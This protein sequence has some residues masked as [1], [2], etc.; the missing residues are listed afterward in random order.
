[1]ASS[2]SPVSRVLSPIAGASALVAL[3]AAIAFT[4]PALAQTV[5]IP[6]MV[7][8]DR[9]VP[10]TAVAV[11]YGHQFK[12]DVEDPGTEMARHNALF[13][14]SHRFDLGEKT[15]LTAMG[16]YTLHGYDFSGNGGA[17]PN[18]TNFYQWDDVHR[19]VLAGVVGHQVGDR[20]RVL[21]GGLFRSWGES[22]ADYGDSI[23]GGLLVGFDY[24]SS[25]TL[26]IGVMVGA[27]SRLEDSAS[28]LPVPILNWRFA[29]GWRWNVGMVSLMDPGVGSTLTWQATD[30][31]EVGAGFTFQS[32]EFR[33]ADRTRAFQNGRNDDGGIGRESE[34]PVFASIRWRPMPRMALDL[35]GG[36]A[37]NGNIRV[38]DNDGDLIA[39]DDYDPAGLLAIKGTIVF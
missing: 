31:V 8:P 1:L 17:S 19:L 16:T 3:L 9:A 28:I 32:R 20:W 35:Q 29:E 4:A 13:V 14:L 30:T 23:T 15:Q 24:Q 25:D 2:K 7:L 5:D 34:I 33:L 21:G 26:T 6:A 27:F 10:P 18:L 39:D 11:Q 36:V 37:L 22:G 38:E 12:T